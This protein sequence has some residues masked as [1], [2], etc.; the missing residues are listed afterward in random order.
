MMGTG[1]FAVP[2]FRWLLASAHDVPA[3]F[4]RPD[5]N[6]HRRRKPPP[7][8]MREVAEQHG[9][10]V[11]APDSINSDEAHQELQKLTADLVVVCDYGQI[12]SHQTLSLAKRGGINLH[13]SLLPKYRGAAPV[14][15]AIY[16]GETETGVSVIHMT[17]R[18]DGGPII[19]RRTT[20]IG[21]DE[22]TVDVELRLSEIGVEAVGE[23]VERL[24][25][26]H[27][28]ESIGEL[29]DPSQATKAPRLSKEDGAVDWSRTA[30]QIKNQVRAFQP[31]PGTYSNIIRQGHEP[32]RL[33]FDKVEVVQQPPELPREPAL[34]EIVLVERDRLLVAAGEGLLSLERVQP[35]GKRAMPIGDWLCGHAVTTD[36]RFESQPAST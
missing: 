16:H 32:A 24:A 1:P 36:D 9:L 4:T 30:Q 35:A 15:W 28:D 18:L 2:T 14:H 6:V 21:P 25:A 29:Q 12:L 3:L 33:I 17:P 11:F 10:P 13:G 5:R 27:A 31:W 26:S 7:N 34:G 19:A 20:P 22:T 23:A 8:P